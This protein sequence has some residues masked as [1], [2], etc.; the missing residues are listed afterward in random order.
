[1]VQMI[2]SGRFRFFVRAVVAG[3][4]R[5]VRLVVDTSPRGRKFPRTDMDD[6]AANNLEQLPTCS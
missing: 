5:D 3:I 6:T 1:M 2:E 4:E